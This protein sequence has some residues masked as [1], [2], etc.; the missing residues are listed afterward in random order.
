MFRCLTICII[1]FFSAISLN[2][3]SHI[4]QPRHYN[5]PLCLINNS[6]VERI[7]L[8]DGM[9]LSSAIDV[10]FS[11]MDDERCRKIRRE[12]V[13]PSVGQEPVVEA[14]SVTNC[15]SKELLRLLCDICG[16]YWSINS[17]GVV[18]FSPKYEECSVHFV[19]ENIYVEEMS[20]T[21]TPC[22]NGGHMCSMDCTFC[23]INDL[24]VP[25]LSLPECASFDS[26]LKVAIDSM[27]DSRC[28]TICIV[29][30]TPK[31]WCG[32]MVGKFD[33]PEISFRELLTL[34]CGAYGY[35]YAIRSDGIICIIV[36]EQF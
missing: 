35:S 30:E 5:C 20:T 24:R 10:A 3:C 8:H 27:N 23:L 17:E 34:L 1:S 11:G 18:V 21:E 9:S 16:Y 15:L 36:K 12:V 28:E 22:C 33:T 6:H 31:D 26:A 19:P 4:N 25:K 14:I 32:P 13:M 7:E 29:V 2:G